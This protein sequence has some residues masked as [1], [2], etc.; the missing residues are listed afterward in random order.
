MAEELNIT[1][2]QVS[3]LRKNMEAKGV[4]LWHKG[5]TKKGVWEVKFSR[6]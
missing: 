2:D 1:T 6:K 3:T 4:F 5:A